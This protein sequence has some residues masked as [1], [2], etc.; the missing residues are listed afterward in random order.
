MVFILQNP[1]TESLIREVVKYC[2]ERQTIA[3]NK[4]AAAPSVGVR[5]REEAIAYEYKATAD[6]WERVQFVYKEES[7]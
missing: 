2:R 1:T 5:K 6:S 4:A 3:K 7:S